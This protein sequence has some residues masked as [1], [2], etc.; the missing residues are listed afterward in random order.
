MRCK[1]SVYFINNKIMLH[2]FN[3]IFENNVILA[4]V[5]S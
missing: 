5:Y 1:G 4:L 3:F 2:D